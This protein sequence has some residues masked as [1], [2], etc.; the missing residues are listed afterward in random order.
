MAGDNGTTYQK[1]NLPLPWN[2]LEDILHIL[3][4]DG[5]L[6]PLVKRKQPEGGYNELLWVLELVNHTTST[7]TNLY[8]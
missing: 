7:M 8:H 4:L 6:A 3:T 2:F 5:F 1:S